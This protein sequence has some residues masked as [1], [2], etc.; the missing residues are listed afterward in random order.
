M[1]ESVESTVIHNLLGLQ[2][3]SMAHAVC[4]SA[5]TFRINQ[6]HCAH[7]RLR[8]SRQVTLHV[9]SAIKPE[10]L[11]ET[12]FGKSRVPS[13]VRERC[14]TYFFD[15]QQEMQQQQQDVVAL[16]LSE[17]DERARWQVTATRSKSLLERRTEEVLML[18]GCMNM[19]GVLEYV[20]EESRKIGVTG[21]RLDLWT[22]VLNDDADLVSC[23]H[24]ATGWSKKVIPVKIQSLY[25][26]LNK[27]HH[28]GKTPFEW[29]KAG[30]LMI[31]EDAKMS[32]L[33]CRLLQCLC[34]S[35]GI[36]SQVVPHK[37]SSES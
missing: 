14:L 13:A 24:T 34:Q 18:K 35:Y 25:D 37:Q 33:D 2:T 21:G 3:I 20:E 17:K 27:H 32:I 28:V 19:R 31:A 36:P 8:C 26:I 16:L 1:N 6:K 12:V 23:I 9:Y 29:T 4:L 10:K 30:G 15:Q 22:S 7:V 11:L 5:N